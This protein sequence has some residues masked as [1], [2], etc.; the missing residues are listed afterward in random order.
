MKLVVNNFL[1]IKKA[2]LNF[3]RFNVVIGEQAQGKSVLAKLG[4]FFQKIFLAELRKSIFNSET[5]RELSDRLVR[6]F[7]TIFPSYYWKSSKFE[8]SFYMGTTSVKLINEK[9][10]GE[11]KTNFEFGEN[12]CLIHKEL[13]EFVRSRKDSITS[14]FSDDG[15]SQ[16]PG[17]LLSEVGSSFEEKMSLIGVNVNGFFFIPASRAFFS[18]VA[19]NVFSLMAEKIELDPLIMQFG[20]QYETVRKA[21]Y[22]SEGNPAFR[23]IVR[24]HPSSLKIS[25]LVNKVALGDYKLEDGVDWLVQGNRKV[26]LNHSSSGQQEALPMLLTLS[27]LAILS[28]R[29]KRFYIEEPE[30]HLFPSSQKNVVSII[31]TLY[32]NFN[33]SF[34]ITTHSPYILTAINNL[35]AAN[36]V[37]HQSKV[38]ED[39]V[40][41]LVDKDELIKYEDVNAYT[42][43]DG[44]LKSINDDEVRLIGASILDS[45]SDDFD[46]VF[47]GLMNIMYGN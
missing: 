18:T 39:K 40:K 20:A 24:K 15:V 27:S 3:N 42:L 46:K 38:A 36:D 22:S 7:L 47:D 6:N 11:Y 14:N 17:E 33:A 19:R 12:L 4:F 9:N 45:V 29:D 34:F 8:I 43:V 26:K 28:N 25:R 1:A 32:N 31:A 21:F 44:V 2:E 16:G 23:D 41:A 30:A 13:G 5:E 10:A 35:I 37:Y